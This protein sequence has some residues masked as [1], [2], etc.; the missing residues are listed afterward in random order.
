MVEFP[1]RFEN[2]LFGILGVTLGIAFPI[3]FY[4]SNKRLKLAEKSLELVKWKAM[5]R[6]LNILNVGAK[7]GMILTLSFLVATPYLPVM[8]DV[9]VEQVPE[10][11]LAQAGVTVML[12]MDA[13]YSMSSSDLQPSRY[14]VATQMARLFVD[15]VGSEDL[16]GYSSFAGEIYDEVLP[17]LNRSVILDVL[18]SN[19]LY[20]STAIGTALDT[21][22]G[23]LEIYEGGRAIVIFSDGKNNMGVLNLTS[24]ADSAAALKIPIFTVFVG[25]YGIA[26]ADPTILEQISNLT[27]GRFY[28]IKSQDVNTLATE[29]SNISHEVKIVSLKA[30]FKTISVESKDY[31]P[32]M[33]ILAVLLMVFLF[34]TWFIGV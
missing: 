25:T 2:P 16:L 20:P 34:L 3:L 30:A 1:V 5:R 15:N 8:A 24:V 6:V 18:S 12:L 7:I 19:A 10:E 28:E 26:D 13:S 33:I 21:A 23:V 22:L 11:R 4:L 32:P 29:V 17:S 27:G 9:P 31:Y 14:Q